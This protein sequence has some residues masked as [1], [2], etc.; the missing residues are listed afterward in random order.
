MKSS[1][2][3]KST[4]KNISSTVLFLAIFIAGFG[5]GSY[6]SIFAASGISGLGTNNDVLANEVLTEEDL[7]PVWKVWN[8]LETR[9][10]TTKDH[11]TTS[12]KIEGLIEG[13]TSSYND[14]YTTYF[15][16]EKLSRFNEAVEGG[17]FSGVGMEIG[18][19]KDGLLQVVSPLKNSP[20]YQV[21][22][23]AGDIIMQIDETN[24]LELSIDEALSMIRGLEGTEV[25]LLVAREGSRQPLEFTI[26]RENIDIP[27]LLT[28]TVD[29]VLLFQS[30]H[31]VLI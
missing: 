20:A 4:I 15:N 21:G 24:S 19:N 14:P 6:Q 16:A 8:L 18:L 13:L 10:V 29:N 31:L 17:S 1:T 25:S 27:V 30:I 28:K 26:V 23:L 12:D 22:I 9:Y 2:N 5:I 11:P 3:T 7:E